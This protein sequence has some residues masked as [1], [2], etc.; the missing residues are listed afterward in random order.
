MA[1][2]SLDNLFQSCAPS[3]VINAVKQ[4]TPLCANIIQLA[5]RH[6]NYW[7]RLTSQRLFGHIFSHLHSLKAEGKTQLSLSEVTSIDFEEEGALLKL[8]YQMLG[9][10]N[11]P[12][13]TDEL[14]NQL[15]KNLV[16]LQRL[17]I[18]TCAKQNRISEVSKPYKK[19]SFIGRKLM[20]SSSTSCLTQ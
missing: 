6:E 12:H 11:F 17:C 1:L 8:I 2:L 16:F 15:V 3:L 13:V 20:V 9:V 19:A 7:V 5:W 18:E 14:S 10:L 4:E